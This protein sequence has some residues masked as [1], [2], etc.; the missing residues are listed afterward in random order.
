MRAG[1]LVVQPKACS[2]GLEGRGLHRI[3]APTI[4]QETYDLL[5]FRGSLLRGFERVVEEASELP[6][7]L[8]KDKISHFTQPR[9]VLK[10]ILEKRTPLDPLGVV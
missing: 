6:T 2:E 4:G 3:I 8:E 10:N 7:S 5:A 9:K 1:A